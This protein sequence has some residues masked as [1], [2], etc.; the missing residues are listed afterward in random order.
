MSGHFKDGLICHQ[1]TYSRGLLFDY[2]TYTMHLHTCLTACMQNYL[3]PFLF[4]LLIDYFSYWS[5]Q[6]VILQVYV[7]CYCCC[8]CYEY[9]CKERVKYAG[10]KETIITTT[11]NQIQGNLSAYQLNQYNNYV[12]ELYYWART[13][14]SNQDERKIKENNWSEWIFF[15]PQY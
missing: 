4:V 12:D 3:M 9:H 2:L 6:S 11:D 15:F 5:I 7:I 13:F 1:E 14:V 10:V 8:C